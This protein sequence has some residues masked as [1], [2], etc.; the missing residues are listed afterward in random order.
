[1]N[2]RQRLAAKIAEREAAGEY[3]TP[4]AL[5][6]IARVVLAYHPKPKSEPAK[7]RERARKKA[8]KARGRPNP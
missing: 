3:Q 5:D 4:P 1:M 8:E 2:A 7:K 6:A